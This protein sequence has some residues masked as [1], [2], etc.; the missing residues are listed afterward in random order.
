VAFSLQFKTLLW[1][2]LA[3]SFAALVVVSENNNKVYFTD[4]AFGYI[5][6]TSVVS[7]LFKFDL[8]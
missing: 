5:F 8:A 4:I 3:L 1:P 2:Y 6:D 7:F